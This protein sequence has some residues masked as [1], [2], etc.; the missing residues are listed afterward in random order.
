VYKFVCPVRLQ[1]G[2]CGDVSKGMTVVPTFEHNVGTIVPNA[3]TSVVRTKVCKEILQPMGVIHEGMLDHRP[4]VSLLTTITAHHKT[5]IV[6]QINPGDVSVIKI[7]EGTT[8]IRPRV[9]A[10]L[11]LVEFLVSLG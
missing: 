9:D 6:S 5:M 1:L 3:W 8:E 4:V 7:L 2:V 10:R 11:R